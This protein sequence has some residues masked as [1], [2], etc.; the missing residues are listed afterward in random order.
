[1]QNMDEIWHV[2][3]NIHTT[4]VQIGVDILTVSSNPTSEFKRGVC[5]CIIVY[6]LL[7]NCNGVAHN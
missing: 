5:M 3:T 2:F 1:M 4:S 6:A 7:Y